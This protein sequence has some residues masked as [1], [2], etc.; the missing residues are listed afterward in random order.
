MNYFLEKQNKYDLFVPYD[1]G[2]A[3]SVIAS[4]T[5]IVKTQNLEKGIYYKVRVPDF[6]FNP[7]DLDNFLLGP[8]DPILEEIIEEA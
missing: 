5:N 4:K 8:K 7:L 1:A 6:I 3:H 2:A